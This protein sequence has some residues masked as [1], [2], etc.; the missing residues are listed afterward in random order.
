MVF[1]FQC[2]VQS[3][4]QWLQDSDYD[5]TCR[6]CSSPLTD[7][8][9]GDCVRLLCY[10][11]ENF[12]SNGSRSGKSCPPEAFKQGNAVFQSRCEAPQSAFTTAAEFIFNTSQLTLQLVTARSAY[13]PRAFDGL[14]Q[15][16][17][18]VAEL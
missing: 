6:L 17:A 18:P 15:N 9:Q 13:Q 10:G 3:Y 12:L 4:L 16:F 2:I 7:D 5:P 14:Q 1:V 8:K 11:E